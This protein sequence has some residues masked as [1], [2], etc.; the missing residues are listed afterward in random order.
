MIDECLIVIAWPGE[1][2]ACRI[3]HA[4]R[5]EIN[6][7]LAKMQTEGIIQPSESPSASSVVLVRKRDGSLCFCVNYQGLNAVTKTNVHPLP[8][9]TTS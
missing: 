4:A 9:K 3:P 6:N 7:Q 1:Q 5:E 8:K 2:V